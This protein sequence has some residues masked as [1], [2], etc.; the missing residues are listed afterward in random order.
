VIV[1]K[2]GRRRGSDGSFGALQRTKV[3]F[4]VVT[5]CRGGV[6]MR[7]FFDVLLDDSAAT[8]VEYSL[9][10]ALIAM[11]AIAAMT[12]FGAKVRTLFSSI[13]SDLSA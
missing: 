4:G 7:A 9:V 12:A 6:D 5:V 2:L 8:L 10:V 3:R 1:V 13:G 11:A